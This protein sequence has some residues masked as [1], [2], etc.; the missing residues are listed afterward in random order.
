MHKWPDLSAFREPFLSYDKFEF[1]QHALEKHPQADGAIPVQ[2]L[3]EEEAPANP[4]PPSQNLHKAEQSVSAQSAA[5][6]SNSDLYSAA[7]TAGY[8][9]STDPPTKKAVVPGPGAIK[10]VWLITHFQCDFEPLRADE[11]YLVQFSVMN[12]ERK[13]WFHSKNIISD[14]DIFLLFVNTFW[15]LIEDML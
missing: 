4:T 2:E 6:G 10:Q 3:E 11:S 14:F 9:G 5:S 12:F 7:A 15:C 13:F 1:V 8:K